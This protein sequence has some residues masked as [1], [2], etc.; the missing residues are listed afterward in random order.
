MGTRSGNYP[1]T[2]GYIGGVEL[3][4]QT[5]RATSCS[6]GVKQQIN[7]PDVIDGA[8]DWTLYQLA[9]IEIDGDIALPVV[10]GGFGAQLLEY[11]RREH[12]TGNLTR[13]DIPVKVAYGSQSGGGLVRSFSGGSCNT[14]EMKATAGE[15]LDATINLWCTDFDNSGGRISGAA[16]VQ[17]VLSWA[18]ITITGIGDSCNI[19]DFSFNVN[20]QL[21]RNYTFC[22]GKHGGY[23]P[24]NISA[25]KRQVS[26][27]IGYQGSAPDDDMEHAELNGT[28]TT[29]NGGNL[30]MTVGGD[31][32]FAVTFKNV[33]Y[34]YQTIE[35]QPGL[36]TSTVNWYAHAPAGEDSI[37]F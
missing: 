28:D 9:G 25:G 10:G 11:I 8:V 4:G 37:T 17:R 15:R 14:L 33:V 23:V 32:G 13:N 19:K 36:I 3:D 18:D 35:A 2:M 7:H 27:S 30:V 26:G 1:A 34:E 31:A 21:S 6:L 12:A 29:P 5:F 20:N 16:D 24:N 22:P